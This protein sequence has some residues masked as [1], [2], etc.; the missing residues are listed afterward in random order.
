MVNPPGGNGRA[1]DAERWLYCDRTAEGA[2][3]VH[4]DVLQL[5]E[6]IQRRTVGVDK[7]VR[8]SLH[9]ASLAGDSSLIDLRIFPVF[10]VGTS[11]VEADCIDLGG[12]QPNDAYSEILPCMSL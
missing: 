6:A 1:A 11:E 8:C 4:V 10:G 12:G 7:L 3:Q 9:R 5:V 2:Y